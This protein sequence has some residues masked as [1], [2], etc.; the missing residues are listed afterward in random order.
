MV[1]KFLFFSVVFVGFERTRVRQY[2]DQKEAMKLHKNSSYPG[3]H[4]QKDEEG[5]GFCYSHLNVRDIEVS[6][7]V[8]SG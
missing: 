2:T 7:H 1:T 3:L 6:L 4:S 5:K 8:I